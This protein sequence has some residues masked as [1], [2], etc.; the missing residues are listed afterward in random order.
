MSYNLGTAS[1]QIIVDGSGAAEGFK[2]AAQSAE[3]F[4]QVIKAQMGA[5]EALSKKLLAVGVAGQAGLGGAV[6]VAATF[7]QALSAVQ[8]VSGATADQM[9]KVSE[10]ALRIGADTA[11]TATEAANAMEE[12]IKAGVSL[13]DTLGGAADA[14]VALAA[15]G[16]V[17]LPRAAEISANAMNTFKLAGTDMMH[18][19]DLIAGA[20]NASAIDVEQMG[21]SLSQAGAVAALAGLK[22]DDLS[23]AIAEMG[24]A[25]IKGSDAGT[26][27]KT[28]L[29]N[30]QP[31]T[32]KQKAKFD[33][34][35]LTTEGMANKFFD[36]SGKIKSMADIQQVLSDA[37]Q[38]MTEQQKLANLEILFG[39]D[40]IRAAA[41]LA[42][43]GADGYNKL[44]TAMGKV[45]ATGVAQT[46]LD[47]L[48][49]SLEQMRGSFESAA[50]SIGTPFLGAVRAVV[51]A[52]TWTVNIFNKLPT[53][54][55]NVIA[56]FIGA[57]SSISLFAGA[58]GL[59]TPTIGALIAKLLLFRAAKQFFAIFKAG[60]IAMRAAGTVMGAAKAGITAMSSAAQLGS[61]KIRN[62]VT[63]FKILRAASLGVKGAMA[64][65]G[66]ALV[67]ATAAYLYFSNKAAESE[68][69]VRSFTDAIREDSGA[70]GDNT[71]EAIVATL[72]KEGYIKALHRLGV[73][74]PDYT[75]AIMGN[76]DAQALVNAQLALTPDRINQMTSG[77]DDASAALV[78]SGNTA[79][80]MT[81]DTKFLQE[82]VT[83]LGGELTKAAQDGKDFD[84]AMGRSAAST[85]DLGNDAAEAAAE[86]NKLTKALQD[87]MDAALDAIDT[88]IRYEGA[89]DDWREAIKK[90]KGSTDA[91]TAAGRAAASAASDLSRATLAEVS[92]L[93]KLDPS[94][95]KAA[96]TMAAA[97]SSFINSAIAAGLSATEAGKL[98]DK[99]RLIP[100]NIRTT[101]SAPGAAVSTGLANRLKQ[102]VKTIP[103]L[104]SVRVLEQGARPSA[105]AVKD[106][107]A[108]LT[109]LPPEVESAVVTAY[110]A[111]GVEAATAA[112]SGLDGDTV[113]ATVITNANLKGARDALAALNAIPKTKTVTITTI[114]KNVTI[115]QT[116]NRYTSQ[117]VPGL[118][119]GGP[120]KKKKPYW[121]GE[122]GPEL[123][124]PGD[125][126]TVLNANASKAL[127]NGVGALK[128]GMAPSVL[129]A[130]TKAGESMAAAKNTG[131]LLQRGNVQQYPIGGAPS[132]EGNGPR[133][134]LNMTVNAPST[135][136]PYSTGSIILGRVKAGL[137]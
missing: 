13:D 114:R 69:R 22:L 106:F 38:G 3:A 84:E 94:G 33:E 5:F 65:V 133:Y 43:N 64:A 127:M 88:N 28:L 17:A 77:L 53:P 18:V 48:S 87:S 4:F 101:F 23:V 100:G 124:F 134:N 9:G 2:V 125:D 83:G 10:A 96:A 19:A 99:Y 15:A 20:A 117:K 92:S 112:L 54:V 68:E 115:N 116:I 137:R 34:L 41:V 8:A 86:L 118:A 104:K 110:E 85:N 46:R 49:G 52:I 21:Q 97:R 1:G 120:I 60:F 135:A 14:T 102:A 107:K 35:G 62:L 11:F 75:N 45:T 47:N 136:D 26:S 55:K 71:K 58:I 95:K 103:A 66:V 44:A 36:A 91:H 131:A 73:S 63:A 74:L 81:A 25:G 72:A 39:S 12:L 6:K 78:L 90:S 40:A 30:L 89:I 61:T 123:I 59:L 93:M 42:A 7:E 121:V 113:N 56:I 70:L 105:A 80:Q 79:T 31:T 119:K 82:G 51:D 129:E 98:A 16:G 111:G 128:S 126:G 132:S 130:I 37:T 50:I 67:A 32:D 24:N 57:A 29:M 109:G 76:S 122:Q 108:S 27:L